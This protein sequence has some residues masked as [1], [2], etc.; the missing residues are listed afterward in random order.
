MIT[1]SQALGIL[2]MVSLC[3]LLLV[4]AS[5]IGLVLGRLIV[6]VL[7]VLDELW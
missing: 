5:I 2:W 3:A 7:E 6:W 4:A 1:L